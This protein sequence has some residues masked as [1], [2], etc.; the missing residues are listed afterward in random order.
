MID[1]IS[2]QS[3]GLIGEAIMEATIAISKAGRS[4]FAATQILVLWVPLTR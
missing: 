3:F 1:E 4:L 2:E